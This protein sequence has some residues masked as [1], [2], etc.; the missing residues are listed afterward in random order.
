MA[1]FDLM[2]KNHRVLSFEYDSALHAATAV[3][4]LEEVAWAPPAILF[5]DGTTNLAALN[6]WWRHRGIPASRHQI[7]RLLLSL[8]LDSTAVLAEESLGLS[9]SDR[10]WIRPTNSG[11][12]WE[13]VNFFDNDFSDELGMLTLETPSAGAHANLMSPNSTAG[14]NLQKKWIVA[15]GQRQLIKG[16]TGL[17][18]Q[19]PFN[20]VAATS[21]HRRLL[22]AD[23]FVPYAL[24]FDTRGV[25]S[26][27]PEFLE[28]NEEFVPAHDL[29]HTLLGTHST[30]TYPQVLDAF[31]ATGLDETHVKE[32]LA[33]M[34]LCDYLI[35]NYDRHLRNFGAIRNVETLEYTRMA[36]IFDSG[37]SLWCWQRHL[38]Y[39]QDWDYVAPPFGEGME[40][41]RQVKLFDA[42]T[43][44]D[45]SRLTG[46][47]DE[48]ADILSKN[49]IMPQQRIE[50]IRK[51]LER[52]CQVVSA[53]VA[54]IMRTTPRS[55]TKRP[56]SK[57]QAGPT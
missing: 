40:P 26:S 46:W 9:L 52:R 14:G 4:S 5:N 18:G 39:P 37:A 50:A 17:F 35:A 13:D 47:P 34:F 6:T 43:W 54:R 20:E 12:T 41:L 8:S 48:A 11:L 30:V 53:T 51:E 1:Q 56:A 49:D 55:S 27:C 57:Q 28:A 21:L 3:I 22:D 15:D 33:K 23:D 7:E 45:A 29:V 42:Y 24:V 44:F 32:A 25:Y 36:P 16:A 38:T 2:N 10:Y 31:V 19:E